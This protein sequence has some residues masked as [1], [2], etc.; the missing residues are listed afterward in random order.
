MD[1]RA[2]YAYISEDQRVDKVGSKTSLSQDNTR[3][4]CGGSVAVSPVLCYLG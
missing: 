3:S 2:F 4:V 1:I